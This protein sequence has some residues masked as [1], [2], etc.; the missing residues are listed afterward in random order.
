[1][2]SLR[3]I[4]PRYTAYGQEGCRQTDRMWFIAYRELLTGQ[5]RWALLDAASGAAR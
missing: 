1:M 2:N 5:L 4:A 3:A